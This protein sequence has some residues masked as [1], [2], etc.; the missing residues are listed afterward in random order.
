VNPRGKVLAVAVV[1]LLSL[2]GWR[3]LASFRE[4]ARIA[5]CRPVYIYELA[6]RFAADSAGLFPPLS[7]LPGK[8]IY[9]PA[10]LGSR[11]GI[12]RDHF[13]DADP[14]PPSPDLLQHTN[15]AYKSIDDW[16]YVYLGYVIEN[17]TQLEAFSDAYKRIIA[18]G[19]DFTTDLKVPMGQ[20]NCDGDTIYRLRTKAELLKV[21]PCLEGRLG[22]LP[23]VMEWPGNH[24]DGVAQAMFYG[25]E[26]QVQLT[27]PG[28]W[29][30]TEAAISIL[31]ELDALGRNVPE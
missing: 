6:S 14:N 7:T 2:A 17:Q 11:I 25:T 8:L 22:E 12:V 20:G 31:R 10:F 1:A 19:G 29:P 15:D 9:D 21:L 24:R 26:R 27:Y 30:M 3:V 16:S 28:E 23:V 4:E 13:C 5:S 18:E